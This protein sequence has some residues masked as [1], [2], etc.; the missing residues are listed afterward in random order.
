MRTNWFYDEGAGEHFPGN[1][2][3]VV[4]FCNRSV[5]SAIVWHYTDKSSA[6]RTGITA[7]IYYGSI[8]NFSPCHYSDEMFVAQRPKINP[9]LRAARAKLVRER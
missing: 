3:R 2:Q 5:R 6:R 9:L 1:L 4:L 8:Y 7:E